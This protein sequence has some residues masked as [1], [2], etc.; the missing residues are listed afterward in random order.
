MRI[1]HVLAGVTLVMLVASSGMYRHQAP[2]T[3]PQAHTKPE[4]PQDLSCLRALPCK[5]VGSVSVSEL[6]HEGNRYDRRPVRVRGEVIMLKL[7]RGACGDYQYYVLKD[8]EGH[9][10]SVTD[11]RHRS[12]ALQSK[13][14]A[15]TGFYRA[16]LHNIDVCQEVSDVRGSGESNQ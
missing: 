13:R 5:P 11:Y 14:I 8:S 4:V 6:L 12:E 1:V 16:E 15:V 9:Y 10:V 7:R 3:A 2:A